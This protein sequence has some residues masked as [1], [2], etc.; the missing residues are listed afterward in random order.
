MQHFYESTP[1]QVYGICGH[2]FAFLCQSRKMFYIKRI[3][4]GQA[5]RY[6]WNPMKSMTLSPKL[7]PVISKCQK[8]SDLIQHQFSQASLNA[9]LHI[10]SKT[11]IANC[12]WEPAPGIVRATVMQNQDCKSHQTPKMQFLSDSIAA[13]FI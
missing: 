8:A 2:K 12:F 11:K 5:L 4:L 3:G 7:L 9:G 6:Q 10:S 13:T 1:S